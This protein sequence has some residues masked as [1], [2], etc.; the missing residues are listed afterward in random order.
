MS[1][2]SA[3]LIIGLLLL[4]GCKSLAPTGSSA[5]EFASA[6]AC[7][8]SGTV[9]AA[10]VETASRGYPYPFNIYLPPCYQTETE[11][12]YPVI[13]LLPGRGGSPGT[14]FAVG[15]NEIADELI[16][17]GES[18]P[19]IIVTTESTDSDPY[20]ESILTDLIPYIESHYRVQTD[21]NHRAVAGGSL[22]GIGAYRMGLR[23][24][25]QFA[26]IGIFGSGVIHGEEE[27]VKTWLNELPATSQPRVFLNC[28]NEDPLMLERTQVTIAML[29][30]AGLPAT[31]II[32]PGGHTYGYWASNFPAYFR[33]VAQDW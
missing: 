11:Q 12:Q 2:K 5:T 33:W 14:W 15:V 20:T 3:F 13:Y 31:S 6:P 18:P 24:P 8:D 4:A 1:R 19:F 17:G 30:E 22:G 16:L 27:Q 9:T 10:E 28:G 26:S 29:E 21:R 25:D 32:S 7:N 23:F